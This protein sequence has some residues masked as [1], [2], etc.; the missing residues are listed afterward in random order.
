MNQIKYLLF[1]WDDTL[2]IDYPE[3]E[4]SMA[5]WQKVSP[6]PDVSETMPLLHQHYKCIVASNAGDSNANLMK[7]AF[8]RISLD[9]YFS[10]FITSKE[11]GATKPSP[12]FFQ[13]IIDM[14]RLQPHETVM[15]GNDYDK[16]I[17]GAKNMGIKT[18]LITKEQGDFPC[19]DYVVCSFGSLVD[20]MR[21]ID[22][23]PLRVMAEVEV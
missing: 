23:F 4:G 6:M 5:F 10:G 7:Q 16:D 13:G 12:A 19:A 2:M 22:S 15:V 14:Y 17:I 20:V 21:A 8:E 3:Y 9:K 18:V 1:D 11:L